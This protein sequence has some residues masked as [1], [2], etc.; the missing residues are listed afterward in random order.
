[1]KLN[2]SLN[3]LIAKFKLKKKKNVFS[4][5][6]LTDYKETKSSRNKF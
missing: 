6:T 4:A 5:P 2:K 3:I 1:M